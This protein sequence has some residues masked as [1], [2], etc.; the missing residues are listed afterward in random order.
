MLRKSQDGYSVVY[1]S[2]C[3]ISSGQE[4]E[5]R[6]YKTGK[7][8]MSGNESIARQIKQKK[9]SYLCVIKS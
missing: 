5:N 4:Y 9:T 1:S 3:S 2:G 7:R 6:Q 8:H